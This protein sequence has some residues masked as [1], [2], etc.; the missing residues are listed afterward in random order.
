MDKVMV[1][2][3]DG[4]LGKRLFSTDRLNVYMLTSHLVLDV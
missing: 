2:G 3:A 1:L 4:F